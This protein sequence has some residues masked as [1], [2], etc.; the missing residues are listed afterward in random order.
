MISRSRLNAKIKPTVYIIYCQPLKKFR[1]SN[2]TAK[3]K[4]YKNENFPI[5]GTVWITPQDSESLLERWKN[6][7]MTDLLQLHNKQPVWSDGR[8]RVRVGSSG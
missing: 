4:Q 3:I 2:K 8:S 7:N 1:G 5:Y 6:N